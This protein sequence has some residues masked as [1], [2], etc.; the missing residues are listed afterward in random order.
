MTNPITR[1]KSGSLYF[2]STLDDYINTISCI[3]DL[4]NAKYV[5]SGQQRS[6][7][8]ES[9]NHVT[10][11]PNIGVSISGDTNKQ[12]HWKIIDRSREPEV[13]ERTLP[14][15]TKTYDTNLR[16]Q[17]SFTPSGMYLNSV[18]IAGCFNILST[19]NHAISLYNKYTNKIKS[20]FSKVQMFWIG[21]D[22]LKL[23]DSGMR[24]TKA[25]QMP[26]VYNLARPQKG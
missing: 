16:G 25:T 21:P 17:L 10:E 18:M 7:V 5:P 12:R 8:F 11:I 24:F 15:G 20:Q 19:D 6:T 23:F 4:A 3:D 22:A 26:E 13:L 1:E 14:D 2:Y 9:C